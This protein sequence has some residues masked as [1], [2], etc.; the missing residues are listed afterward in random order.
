MIWC[1]NHIVESFITKKEWGNALFFLQNGGHPKFS[2]FHLI[3]I[4]KRLIIIL[5]IIDFLIPC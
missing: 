3:P 2:H 5:E 1:L 4:D